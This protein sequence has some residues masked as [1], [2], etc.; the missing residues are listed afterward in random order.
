MKRFLLGALCLSVVL[1][2]QSSSQTI[3]DLNL[4]IHGY[5]TQGFL[6]TTHNDAF[7]AATTNGSPAWTEAV[8]NMTVQP[9]SGL[10]VGVQARYQLL[11][12]S[13]N[14]ITLD[15]AA[16]D[17]RVNDNFGVRVGK[18]KTPWGL[19]NETQDIDPSYMWALLPQSVYDLT[20]RNADLSHYGAIA[21]GDFGLGVR[22]GKLEYRIWGGEQVVPA[23]D[24]QFD[25]L[26]NSGN[27]PTGPLNYSTIGGA[28]RW[29]TPLRGLMF[30][31]SNAK[32]NQATAQL[33]GG[34]EY[35]APWNNLSWFGRFD[36]GKWMLG[37]EW[38]R[39][40]SAATLRITGLQPA[41]SDSDARGWFVMASYKLRDKYS[42]GAYRSEYFDKQAEL[43]PDRYS[44]DWTASFRCDLNQ[45]LYLKAEQH[46]VK[47]TALSVDSLH[48]PDPRPDFLLTALKLGVSF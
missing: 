15:W 32:E 7:Y 17:Y 6:Y 31:A 8:V 16:A 42:L 29:R 14:S 28:L 34:T 24:G 20:T 19:L 13:G 9:K 3:D 27:G 25:D 11:G 44:K 37:S 21:Y 26:N 12:T 2:L 4:Q 10:S 1:T 33:H 23:D 39:Q 43:G 30:G 35:F 22:G 48:N 47:G 36:R 40:A 45:Y 18:V 46:F 5:A 38:N 41:A